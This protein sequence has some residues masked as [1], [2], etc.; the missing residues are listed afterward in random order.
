LKIDDLD[1][2]LLIYGVKRSGHSSPDPNF[3]KGSHMKKIVLLLVLFIISGLAEEASVLP[4]EVLYKHKTEIQN[5]VI[6]SKVML[7]SKIEWF[8]VNNRRNLTSNYLA[9][10][11]ATVGDRMVID[12]SFNHS[13]YP[14]SHPVIEHKFNDTPPYMN[15]IIYTLT[16]NHGKIEQRSFDIRRKNKASISEE[17]QK[18][19]VLNSTDIDPKAWEETSVDGAIKALF[20]SNALKIIKPTNPNQYLN[21]EALH[22]LEG[23]GICYHDTEY[24]LK[25]RIESKKE[26]TSIAVFSSATST[27]LLAVFNNANNG[28]FY[29]EAPFKIEKNGEILIVAK[30]RD[31]KLY[32]SG[33]Y[34]FTIGAIFEDGHYTRIGFDF[35]K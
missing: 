9:N 27:A 23:D 7:K 5:G 31:G 19:A 17:S 29:V 25:I 1:P 24:P 35:G 12:A 6:L 34:M 16:D 32:R 8:Y 26:L 2:N 18:K 20:G 22:C 3:K 33:S 14:W 13:L 21:Q 30:G 28:I 4:S 11:T 10:I 15:K